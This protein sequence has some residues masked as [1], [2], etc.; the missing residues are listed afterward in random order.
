LKFCTFLG[1]SAFEMI[2]ANQSQVYDYKNLEITIEKLN[3]VAILRVNNYDSQNVRGGIHRILELLNPSF[4][5]EDLSNKIILL[6]PNVLAPDKM[7][8]TNKVVVEEIALLFNEIGAKKVLIGDSTMTESITSMA[9][10]RSGLKQVAENVNTRMI[11]FLSEEYVNISHDSFRV[12][13]VVRI[14]KSVV[15][16]DIIINIPKMK[17]HTGYIFT[18]AI[19]NFF[20][21]VQDKL[22]MHSI[23]KDKKKFQ[24]MLGDIHNAVL[25]T[26]KDGNTKPVLHIMDAIVA[27]EG[28]GPRSGNHKPFHCLIASFSPVALDSLAYTLMGGNPND[29]EAIKSLASRNLW[30]TDI[31]DLVILGDQWEEFKQKAKLP[32]LKNLQT[33]RTAGSFLERLAVPILNAFH[34]EIKISHKKCIQCNA[35]STHCPTGAIKRNDFQDKMIIDRKKCINCFCCGEICPNDALKTQISIIRGL[36]NGLKHVI[37]PIADFGNNFRIKTDLRGSLGPSIGLSFKNWMRLFTTKGLSTFK[38]Y[39]PRIFLL[40]L[41]NTF[42]APL[43]ITESL[44]YN[45]LIKNVKIKTSP[46]F[47]LGHWRTGTTHIQ[48]LLC[49]DPQFGYISQLHATF[50]KSFMNYK[51]LR[52]FLKLY[53]PETRPMDNMKLGVYSP[54][55]EEMALGNLFP[56]SFYNGFYLPKNMIENYNTFIRLKG[57]SKKI[58]EQWKEQYLHLLKKATYVF[59]G[60]QLILKNPANTARIKI[61]LEMFPDAKFIHIYRNPYVVFQSTVNFYKKAIQPFMLQEIS[62]RQ[63]ETNILNIYKEMMTDYFKDKD[64]IPEDN[65]VE[66][67][68]E[69][70]EENPIE[71]L[72]KIYNKLEIEN[73]DIAKPKFE[74]YL[75]S[76]KGYKKNSYQFSPIKISEIE[77]NWNFTINKWKYQVP[78]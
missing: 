66:V 37:N 44:K 21:L 73:Y 56:Y 22:K 25:C 53:L 26:G 67:K 38:Y 78:K 60:K 47:I 77:K 29:L 52:N 5:H 24:R 69:D 17:T 42:Q 3:V 20:G 46:I 64:L 2:G 6:K 33:K 30:V 31:D 32:P 71:E 8:Y 45:K 7:A 34:P 70:L 14:P 65:L 12:N 36:S 16:A 19:K 11:N 9:H 10:K 50:P 63:L 51:V 4:L 27:M 18:G 68:F 23:C 76:I 43:K 28:K 40:N 41:I 15:E 62:D 13:E 49:Q 35:C 72:I 55:E 75:D 54:T 58:I 57:G 1:D 48:N 61:L 74:N 59:N 39:Y